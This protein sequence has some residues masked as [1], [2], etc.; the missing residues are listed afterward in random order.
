METEQP[1]FWLVWNPD[2][3]TPQYRYNSRI[4][5]EQDARMLARKFPG[6]EFYVLQPVSAAVTSDVIIR[7][8]QSTDDD[9]KPC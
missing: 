9:G 3:I 4:S 1:P 7:R 5:A 6:T 2:G 8:F